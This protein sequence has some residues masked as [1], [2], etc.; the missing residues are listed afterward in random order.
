MVGGGPTPRNRR[1]RLY[2]KRPS[3]VPT[4]AR[5]CKGALVWC[6]PGPLATESVEALDPTRRDDEESQRHFEEE[7]RS[8]AGCIGARIAADLAH[9]TLK[10]ET[11]VEMHPSAILAPGVGRGED[12]PIVDQPEPDSHAQP[13]VPITGRGAVQPDPG[14]AEEGAE[15]ALKGV[16]GLVLQR[17]APPAKAPQ[18]G[19]MP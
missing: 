4:P 14:R 15:H 18:P 2:G 13:G 11:Q 16:D 19:R 5:G 10:G 17:G 8:R 3:R 6:V 7:Q 9:T 1:P 12:V